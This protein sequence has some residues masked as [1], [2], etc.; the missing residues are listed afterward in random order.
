MS[1]IFGFLFV[2]SVSGFDISEYFSGNDING[3]ALIDKIGLKS[4]VFYSQFL[5]ILLPAIIFLLVFHSKN[6]LSYIKIKLPTDKTFFVYALMLLFLS[7]PLIQFSAALNEKM[8]FADWM[9]GESDRMADITKQILNMENVWQLLLNVF[10]IAVMP[11]LGEELFF[12][13]GIQNELVSGFKNKDVA[14]VLTAILFS[15]F[16]LQFD[17]FLPRIFLGLILG[18]VYYWSGSIWLSILLHFINNSL[19]VFAAYLSQGKIDEL[20]ATEAAQE[21]I[22]LYI[23]IMSLVAILVLR[24][25]M[26]SMWKTENILEDKEDLNDF[27]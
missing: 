19:L 11:A 5:T 26:I 10:L 1:Q 7:Y 14:I 2:M 6:I 15:F 17:G 13:A 24:N 12:R 3:F 23:L 8:F 27:V 21:K 9:Q 25:K 4:F 16:H 20:V 18:Y 22:P